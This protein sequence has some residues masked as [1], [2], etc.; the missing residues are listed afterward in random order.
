M[1]YTLHTAKSFYEKHEIAQFE[2]YGFTFKVAKNV[3]INQK[4]S[5]CIQG[6]GKVEINTLDNLNKLYDEFGTLIFDKNDIT[7]YNDYVE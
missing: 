7:I 3:C 6:E 1:E 2:K 5:M 4:P